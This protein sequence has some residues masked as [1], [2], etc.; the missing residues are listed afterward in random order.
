ML[1]L[2][3]A[4]CVAHVCEEDWQHWHQHNS[5]YCL[6][7]IEMWACCYHLP[8]DVA[9]AGCLAR[10]AACLWCGVE[11]DEFVYGMLA[12][13]LLRH[14]GFHCASLGQRHVLEHLSLSQ[15]HVHFRVLILLSSKLQIIFISIL[16]AKN[17]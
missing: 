3:L 7:I 5:N 1:D 13:Q 8:I 14:S 6:R 10:C 12:T 11:P 16:V 17:Q 15:V 4:C 9:Y 2:V